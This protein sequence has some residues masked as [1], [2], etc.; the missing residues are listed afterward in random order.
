MQVEVQ[1]QKAERKKYNLTGQKTN[2]ISKNSK[3]RDKEEY[4]CNPDTKADKISRKRKKCL[5]ETVYHTEKYCVCIQERTDPGKCK[6]KL[7]GKLT[8]E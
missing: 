3:L 1:A 5:A 2:Q 8:V 4:P 6:N 7:T